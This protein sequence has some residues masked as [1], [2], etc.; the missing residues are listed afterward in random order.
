MSRCCNRFWPW[1]ALAA[2]AFC[3]FI[4]PAFADAQQSS[5][6]ALLAQTESVR[7][8]DHSQF[9]RLLKQLHQQASGMS[10]HERWQL[11]YLDAWQASF[12]NDYANADPMLRDVIDHSDDPAL[13]AKA[14][15]VLMGDLGDNKHYVE[16]FEL[17]DRLVTNLPDMR[18]KL[19]RFMVLSYVSQL[20]GSAGQYDLAAH[21][22]REIAQSLPPGQTMCQP[23]T[24]LLSVLYS[25]HK[26]TSSSAELQRGID[27][28]QTAREPIFIDT[29]QLVKGSLYLDEDHPDKALALLQQIAPNVRADQYYSNTLASQVELAQAYWK[30]GDDDNA[31]KAALAALAVS[32]PGDVSETLRDAY[33]VLYSIEKK[34]GNAAAA[35]DYY[36]HYAAQNTGYLNDVGARAL[37]YDVAQQ[38]VL[39]Q[40]LETEKLSK[41]NS[42]LQLQQ[43]LATK[44]VETGR[45]YITLL[46][47]ALASIVFW[48]FRLKRSQLRFKELSC[49]DGLTGVFN[50]QHFISEAHRVL[51]L[52]EKK[53][54]VACLISIDL[55]HFKQVNDTHGHAIGDAVLKHTVTICKQQLRP[56]D[57]FGRMGG[58]EFGILLLDCSRE[59]GS[60]IA[61]RIRTAIEATPIDADGCV[62]SFSASI[63]LVCTETCGYELQRLCTEADAALYKAKRTGRNRVIVDTGNSGFVGTQNTYTP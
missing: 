10:T 47:L 58:E 21:Y 35:L 24:R 7:T 36:E 59:Q 37:A 41:Q 20:L 49:L 50:H 56:N 53:R 1:P 28:C 40:K 4:R 17:A 42:V 57:L 44:A 19:A 29:I 9:L 15:A 22:I 3:V 51:R 43:A 30:L 39:A 54:G 61:H 12:Q 5:L 63:G 13:A 33:Q 55:D 34:H 60:L 18:D 8:T 48:L 2:M 14:S 62:V 23:A 6:A 32:D 31:R 16:A 27:A 11:R 38:R 25:S 46:L 52:L 45:L 26:L